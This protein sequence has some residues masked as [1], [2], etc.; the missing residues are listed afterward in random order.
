MSEKTSLTTKSFSVAISPKIISKIN[1]L[2]DKAE[3]IASEAKDRA[4]EAIAYDLECGALLTDAKKNLG[5]GNWENWI[6]KECNFDSVTAWRYMKLSR[7]VNE[8]LANSNLSHVKDLEQSSP[9]TLRQAYIATGIFPNTPKPEKSEK[10]TPLVVHVSHIDAIVL[11][12]RKTIAHK[13]ASDW[14][15][16]EREALINDL[17][18][19][20]EIYNELIELQENSK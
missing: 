7:K 13:P 12:Y 5:H 17:T 9:K 3:S 18:P 1:E 14:N 10:I 20:M 2:H 19:L 8:S 11:W 15:F 6:A 4:Q 16:I